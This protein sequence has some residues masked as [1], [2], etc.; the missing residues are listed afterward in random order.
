[1]C[2]HPDPSPFHNAA[3]PSL[4]K[5]VSTVYHLFNLDDTIQP[6]SL[7]ASR[8]F[9]WLSTGIIIPLSAITEA[10]TDFPTELTTSSQDSTPS[11]FIDRGMTVTLKKEI[12]RN[13][14]V[15]ELIK[16]RLGNNCKQVH[17]IH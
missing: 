10:I 17:I 8:D 4:E 3:I 15:E 2:I 6:R 16:Q 1:M 5:L 12:S 14:A 9:N 7:S 13:E 11:M